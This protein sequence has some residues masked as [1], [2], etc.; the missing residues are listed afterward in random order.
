MK[1]GSF[2]LLALTLLL[3]GCSVSP[4]P[5]SVPVPEPEPVPQGIVTPLPLTVL[6]IQ[7]SRTEVMLGQALVRHFL[8]GPYY[9]M[10]TPLLLTRQYQPSHAAYTSDSQRMLALF[11]QQ[12]GHW[13]FVSVNVAQRGVINL[14]ELQH[15]N[16]R[17]YALVLKRARICLN[18]GANRPPRWNGRGWDYSLQ[19]GRFECSGQTNGSLFQPGSGLP[20]ALGPY[21]EAGDTVLYSRDRQSLQQIASLLKHQFRHLRVPQVRPATH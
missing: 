3:A 15:Q 13:G 2:W 20:G 6:P 14:F 11:R 21:A 10:T 9:R 19:S 12:E 4:P 5:V 7:D 8:T 18:A 1:S 16:A 17:G